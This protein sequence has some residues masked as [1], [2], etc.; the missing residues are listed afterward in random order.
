MALTIGLLGDVMLGRGVGEALASTPPMEL[1]DAE[2]RELA[3]A[4]DL[5]VCNLECCL[6][7]RGAPTARVRGKPFFFRGPTA[8]VE[9]LRAIGARVAGLANNHALDFGPEALADTVAALE[10]AGIEPVGAGHGCAQARRSVELSV[11]GVRVG[12]VAV[13]DHPREFAATADDWGIAH[14]PLRER[15]PAWL[16]EEIQRLEARCDLVL[17]FLHWG[18][19]M[20]VRPAPWQRSLARELVGAGADLVAGHS[21]HLFHGLERFGERTV[22]YDL[23]DALDD[24]AIDPRLRND[25]GLLVLWRPGSA[26]AAIEL[27]GLR[28]EYCHTRLASGADADWIARRLESACGELG[29]TVERMAEQH[30]VLG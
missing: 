15:A 1:W 20:T 14:A 12:L 7:E 13:S 4:C 11:A 26:E 30:F 17:A 28:L 8:A 16:L 6:S 23:G 29:T 10:R 21:A 24:Y 5:V 3:C 18:P 25:L 19:N 27:V 2:L 22:A 9:S